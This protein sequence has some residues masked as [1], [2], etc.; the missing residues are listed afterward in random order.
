MGGGELLLSTLGPHY[1]IHQRTS[2]WANVFCW[3][4]R[5]RIV[6]VCVYAA[7]SE[8]T[9][10][11]CL[12]RINSFSWGSKHTSY[13]GSGHPTDE[14]TER[15]RGR[16]EVTSE[17]ETVEEGVGVGGGYSSAT[18]LLFFPSPCFLPSLPGRLWTGRTERKRQWKRDK[19]GEAERMKASVCVY[20]CVWH[21]LSCRCCLP[22][23][24]QPAS[25]AVRKRNV[26]RR[27][28]SLNRFTMWMWDSNFQT[29]AGRI[30][31]KK[32][33]RPES[34]T[35]PAGWPP[36]C[37]HCWDSHTLHTGFWV[38]FQ[39]MSFIITFTRILILSPGT[40]WLYVAV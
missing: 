10:A 19:R 12:K 14:S 17:S 7:V 13:K 36:V 16:R 32:E 34:L 38:C 30:P 9:V 22:L 35:G 24:L 21:A 26:F 8:W 6:R 25:L 15:A 3:C 39:F 18:S 4:V 20:V 31:R 29:F 23:P 11:A 5:V 40:H 37:S 2:V 1:F 28:D 33:Q 27:N